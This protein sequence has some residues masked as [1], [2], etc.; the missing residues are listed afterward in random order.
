MARLAAGEQGRRI[1]VRLKDDALFRVDWPIGHVQ[2][3]PYKRGHRWAAITLEDR[4]LGYYKR[5]S[6]A[7]AALTDDFLSA[8]PWDRYK[9]AR[10][11]FVEALMIR[12]LRKSSQKPMGRVI[13][14]HMARAIIRTSKQALDFL[15]SYRAL[16]RY[17]SSI[18]HDP[19]AATKELAPKLKPRAKRNYNPPRNKHP[20]I[21]SADVTIPKDLKL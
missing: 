13:A 19:A 11:R 10:T 15:L 14:R 7:R 16:M 18:A 8:R 17:R 5:R 21:T 20:R 4:V 2:K 9:Q 12:L 3:V 1:V 6:S